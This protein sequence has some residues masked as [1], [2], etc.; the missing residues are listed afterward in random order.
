MMSFTN[1][2]DPCT[3]KPAEV[4][5]NLVRIVGVEGPILVSLLYKRYVKAAGFGRT[6]RKIRDAL[7]IR[8]YSAI[9]SKKLESIS[10]PGS[11]R[12]EERI[13]YLPKM[14]IERLR[15]RGDRLLSEVPVTEI[16]AVMKHLTASESMEK[17]A[18]FRAVLETYELQRLTGESQKHLDIA[19]QFLMKCELFLDLPKQEDIARKKSFT[20][21]ECKNLVAW[22]EIALQMT[23][24]WE[25]FLLAQVLQYQNAVAFGKGPNEKTIEE[26]RKAFARAIELGFNIDEE[27]FEIQNTED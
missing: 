13:V 19:Y 7:K 9:R 16:V 14:S 21:Q 12:F 24:S 10:N 18:L 20:G 25:K 8:I 22:N 4:I 5:D 2:P 23:N 17:E 3:G 15:T 6:G 27:Y 1:F 11:K 26:T